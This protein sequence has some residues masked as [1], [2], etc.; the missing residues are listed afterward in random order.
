MTIPASV[1]LIYRAHRINPKWVEMLHVLSDGIDTLDL[2]AL[3]QNIKWEK[4]GESTYHAYDDQWEY[5]CGKWQ[6]DDS[7]HEDAAA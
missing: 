2:L 7:H 4:V 1:W 3:D 6:I 5:T